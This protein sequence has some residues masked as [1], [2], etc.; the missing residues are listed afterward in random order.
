MDHVADALNDVIVTEEITS[1]M[2]FWAV[3]AIGLTGRL[4]ADFGARVVRLCDGDP[5]AATDSESDR[6]NHASHLRALRGFL[7]HGKEHIDLATRE[8]IAERDPPHRIH[9]RL[10]YDG[11]A[12][13][14]SRFADAQPVAMSGKAV[15]FAGDVAGQGKSQNPASEF[16]IAARSGLLDIVGRSDAR[17]L[18]LGGH[19]ISYATGLS[20]FLAAVALLRS[21]D[22]DRAEVSALGTALWTNWKSLA[23]AAQG[24]PVPRRSAESGKWRTAPCADGHVALVYFDRDWPVIGKMTGDLAIQT[25]AAGRGWTDRAKLAELERRLEAWTLDHTRAEVAAASKSYGLAMGAV[26]TPAELVTDPQYQARNF[27][28]SAESDGT[29]AAVRPRLPVI[30]TAQGGAAMVPSRRAAMRGAGPLAGIRV[31]DLGILTAGA[32][33][34]AILADLGADVIKVESPTYLDPF[35]GTPGTSRAEGWW[36]N[37]DAF[38]STNRNKRG[39]CLDLKSAKGR[40]IFLRLAAQSDVVVENFRRGV[41]QKLGLGYYN[42]RAANGSIILASVSSQGESGPDAGNI[43][44]GSTLEATSGL[45][46]MTAYEDGV[47]LVTGMHLNYPDQVGSVFA[48]AAIVAALRAAH[49]TGTGAHLDISQRELATYLLGEEIMAADRSSGA[50]GSFGNASPHILLQ[51]VFQSK[52]GWVAVTIPDG[53]R[54]SRALDISGHPLAGTNRQDINDSKRALSEW[55]S[56]RTADAVCKVLRENRIAA[57]RVLDGKAALHLARE[58]AGGAICPLAYSPSGDIVKG[59]PLHF[60]QRPVAVACAAPDLGQHTDVVLRDILGLSSD[61]IEELARDNVIG[62]RPASPNASRLD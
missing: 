33:T 26:W 34:S 43:S 14:V 5:L 32:S 44:F 56:S 20:G 46:A 29:G 24:R 39:I 11:D 51:D 50:V 31:I 40:E 49:K 23:A 57:E 2:P 59:F 55:M 4:A 8:R 45:A 19:Q 12:D 30:A 22:L 48:A 61:A 54:L 1:A 3:L 25:V 10:C 58:I 47:P 9:V 17:P 37:S 27:F 13:E 28:V 35:R 53:S 41:M 38:K 6:K 62:T 18:K 60:P 21:D 36:N 42:L 15:A 16:T 52:D 7:C